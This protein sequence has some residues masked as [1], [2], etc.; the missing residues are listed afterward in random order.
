MEDSGEGK[1]L[2]KFL[3]KHLLAEVDTPGGE[4]ADAQCDLKGFQV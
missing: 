4:G 1:P 2:R 3:A